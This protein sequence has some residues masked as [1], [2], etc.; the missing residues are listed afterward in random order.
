MDIKK[1]VFFNV[2]ESVQTNNL[3]VLEGNDLCPC[4][5]FNFISYFI[6]YYLPKLGCP[7]I[8][9][10]KSLYQTKTGPINVYETLYVCLCDNRTPQA[11]GFLSPPLLLMQTVKGCNPHYPSDP[12]VLTLREC[13]GT[14]NIAH[15]PPKPQSKFSANSYTLFPLYIIFVP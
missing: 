15:P 13:L 12:P 1:I 11:I 7:L 10:D 4:T 3:L 6:S 8:D 2:C 9:K 5:L 14:L